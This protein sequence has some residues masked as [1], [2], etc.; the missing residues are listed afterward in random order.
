VPQNDSMQILLGN[1]LCDHL[2]RLRTFVLWFHA[3]HI[4]QKVSIFSQDY[5][6]M[7]LKGFGIGPHEAHLVHV[8]QMHGLVLVG[9]IFPVGVMLP[10]FA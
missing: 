2:I 6:L 4:A 9:D 1:G 8:G 3:C 5:L 10:N 7:F